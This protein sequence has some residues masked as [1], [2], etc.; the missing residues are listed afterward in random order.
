ML[1]LRI[2]RVT[3]WNGTFLP[4]HKQ[5][6]SSSAPLSTWRALSHMLD[7]FFEDQELEHPFFD[8]MPTGELCFD[9]L[10]YIVQVF[11]LNLSSSTENEK[12]LFV[13]PFSES[14]QPH[15][16]KIAS[17]LDLVRNMSILD[18]LLIPTPLQD[19]IFISIRLGLSDLFQKEWFCDTL[20]FKSFWKSDKTGA[21]SIPPKLVET[22]L[23]LLPAD[24]LTEN[25]QKQFPT[26]LFLSF[27][28]Y[29]PNRNLITIL[30]DSLRNIAGRYSQIQTT[31]F[32]HIK[33]FCIHIKHTRSKYV[34]SELKRLV[35]KFPCLE[36]VSFL[37]EKKQDF[38]SSDTTQTTLLKYGTTNLWHICVDVY[39][40]IEP[41]IKAVVR[42]VPY[43]PEKYYYRQHL[44]LGA[45]DVDFFY[46]FLCG[47]AAVRT[48]PLDKKNYSFSFYFDLRDKTT[49]K[50]SPLSSFLAYWKRKK[51][52]HLVPKTSENKA[53]FRIKHFGVVVL[54]VSER[55]LRWC[56]MHESGRAEKN[57]FADLFK[58]L[59]MTK[60]L[61]T[62][63]MLSMT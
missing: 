15:K 57:K 11:D 33:T 37:V 20:F 30:Y 9:L 24:V 21:Q 52:F 34:M 7:N 48:L 19:K 28:E 13:I 16:I 53:C 2:P 36:Q 55:A 6:V 63:K 10:D 38:V 54:F 50:S 60:T 46:R 29:L 14:K 12:T 56:N 17:F 8:V 3:K 44:D 40:Y 32:S 35:F 47:L 62:S 18:F 4:Q 31:P 51:R 49:F 58:M 45:S 26:Q 61:S 43:S 25:P 23:N 39:K 42:Y 59:S 5:I 27:S 22:C 41:H 1:A